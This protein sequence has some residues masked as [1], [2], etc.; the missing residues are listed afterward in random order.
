MGMTRAATCSNLLKYRRYLRNN[1]AFRRG[2]ACNVDG[3]CISRGMSSSAHK[4]MD[5]SNIHHLPPLAVRVGIISAAVGLATPLF[6]TAGVARLWYSYLPRTATGQYLKYVVGFFGGGGGISILY[7]YVLPFLRDHS[8][9]VL[10]F[11][12]ANGAAS[13]FWFLIGECVFGLQ[14]MTGV[15]SLE[16]LKKALPTM[17]SSV[18]I[19]PAG[20]LVTSGLPIGGVVIGALTAISAPLLWP[21]AFFICWD[22]NLRGLILDGDSL[23]LMDLYQ[24]F[25][26]PVGLP[27]GV[28]SGLSMH[29]ALK[30]AI[31]GIPGVPWTTT[32][33]PVLG[34]LIGISSAYFYFFQTP[35]SDFMW[36]PRMDCTTGEIVSYNPITR[37]V[38]EDIIHAT[39]AE[40]QRNFAFS[41]HAL[42]RPLKFL[43]NSNFSEEQTV[44]VLTGGPVSIDGLLQRRD[45]FQI[46]DY[47]VRLKH[48]QLQIDKTN[49]RRDVDALNIKA[50]KT[51]GISN[52]DGFLKTVEL[53]VIAQRRS[54]QKV[55]SSKQPSLSSETVTGRDTKIYERELYRIVAAPEI[56]DELLENGLSYKNSNV[57]ISN[58]GINLLFNNLSIFED[59]LY[60]KLQYKIADSCLKED[61]M[62]IA[63]N[64]QK[65]IIRV[66]F[67]GVVAGLFI[68]VTSLMSQK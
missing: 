41:L 43:Q 10:P 68:G 44:K 34:A 16:I 57:S 37:T 52:L 46:I 28:I 62:L 26:I 35:S 63:Y 14:F 1:Y 11:A 8:N 15:I 17:I 27:V 19:S 58:N 9:F 47:L 48:L 61:E 49:Y 30:S 67:V 23:W 7:N 38:K 60:D 51:I 53:A 29:Y 59:E 32:S 31:V 13:G 2:S 3:Y 12:L 42:R 39:T 64:T 4:G 55:T 65:S 50:G 22:D 40:L 45:I 33:L 66:L 18:F 54:T 21:M 20:G 24:Y 56:F 25:G 6:A 5:A 36:E